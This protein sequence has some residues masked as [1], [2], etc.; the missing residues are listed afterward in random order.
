MGTLIFQ[1][2]T[3]SVP[4][5]EFFVRG[6]GG[7]EMSVSRL[8]GMRRRRAK[9]LMRSEKSSPFQI[10]EGEEDLVVKICLSMK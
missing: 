2:A 10:H 3:E 5:N 6:T 9:K 7:L 4:E 8:R 1:S